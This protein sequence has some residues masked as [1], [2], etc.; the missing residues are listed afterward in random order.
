M[1]IIYQFL[2]TDSGFNLFPVIST[3]MLMIAF[4]GIVFYAIR[5]SKKFTEDMSNLPLDEKE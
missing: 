1:K 4:I 3:V 5:I 2:E